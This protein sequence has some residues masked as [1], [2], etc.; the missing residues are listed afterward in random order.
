[1]ISSPLAGRL[2]DW[3]GPAEVAALFLFCGIPWWAALT[4]HSSLAF[5]IV[6]YAIQNFFVAAVASPITVELAAL[7]RNMDGIGYAHSYG[8]FTIVNGLGNAGQSIEHV[9]IPT[10]SL[11]LHPAWH[12]SRFGCWRPD[13]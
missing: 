7:T 12:A 11:M 5:L 2:A 6:S 10:V 1:M 13:L 9:S 4:K 3:S 8:A